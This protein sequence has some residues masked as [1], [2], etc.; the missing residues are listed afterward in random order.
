MTTTPQTATPLRWWT[1]AQLDEIASRAETAWLKW[2]EAWLCDA[3]VG[4]ALAQLA[5]EVEDAGSWNW[6]PMG[7]QHEAAGWLASPARATECVGRALFD[8]Y[9]ANVKPATPPSIAQSVAARAMED[10][11]ARLRSQFALDA[12]TDH[13]LFVDAACLRPWSGCVVIMLPLANARLPILL[14]AGCVEDTLGLAAPL[15][16]PIA[17]GPV[18][19]TTPI[20]D[21]IAHHFITV[22][23]ELDAC[24]IDLG[25]LAQLAPGDVLSLT[26]RLD[27]PMRLSAHGEILCDAFLGQ[28]SGHKAVELLQSERAHSID[29]STS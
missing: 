12:P 10:L 14:N 5:H 27:T 25:T 8:D 6:A 11:L 17:P 15:Q 7:A 22:R 3:H 28:R 9:D 4:G 18:E 21:A 24:E 1:A 2:C 23:V 19:P 26:H 20:S 13:P 16:R 29:S